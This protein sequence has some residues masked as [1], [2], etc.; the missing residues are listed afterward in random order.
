[1]V[2]LMALA[3]CGSAESDEGTADPETA[4]TSSEATT[5]T[6]PATTSSPTTIGTTTSSTTTTIATTT[7][8]EA[9]TTTTT[10]GGDVR[11]VF[12]LGVGDCFDDPDAFGDVAELTFVSCDEP[13]D[14]EAYHVFDLADGEFPGDDAIDDLVFEE[15]IDAFERYVTAE[16]VDSRLDVS[17]F[18]PTQESWAAGD[19][20]II[21]ILYDLTF[22]KLTY[23]MAGT[24]E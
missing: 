2:V 6:T 14:N 3:A 1:M 16:Y 23:S 13:H 12:T 7:T 18:A 11:D 21:C 8:T 19:R 24:G 17:Y 22:A 4:P 9:A 20:E 10:T 5:T 15:C